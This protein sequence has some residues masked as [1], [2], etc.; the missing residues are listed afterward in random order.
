MQVKLNILK[1]NESD[2]KG[3]SCFSPAVIHEIRIV[4]DDLH[5]VDK[6]SEV[7]YPQM[8]GNLYWNGRA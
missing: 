5:H 3:H 1:W 6:T 7:S 4:Q 8:F 2:G